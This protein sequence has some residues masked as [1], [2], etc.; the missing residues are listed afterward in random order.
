MPEGQY[1]HHQLVGCEV[2]AEDGTLIGRVTAV[3]GEMGRSRLV[4]AGEH[5]RH[6]IP[7][8]EAI[9]TVAR[10]SCGRQGLELRV[11]FKFKARRSVLELVSLSADA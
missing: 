6:E 10:M 8:A 11:E 1:Y 9:C 5:R 2:V 4:V 3:E 7:L